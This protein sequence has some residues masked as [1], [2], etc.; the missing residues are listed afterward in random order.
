MKKI[1]LDNS[2]GFILNRTNIR[3]KNNLLH[4]FKDYDITPEQ[5]AVL[6]RLWIQDGISPKELAELTSKDQPTIVRILAK[7]QNKGYLFRKDNP[8]DNRS[9]LIYLTQKGKEVQDNLIPLA[10]EALGKATR[11]ID[12]DQIEQVKVVLNQIFQ[13]LE[14]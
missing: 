14:S 3:M 12:Q 5:W 13:N 4:K 2:H 7:L 1:D 9:L 10:F 11:G 8:E 6:N